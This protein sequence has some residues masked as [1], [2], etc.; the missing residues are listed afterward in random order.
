[1]T[2]HHLIHYRA[3]PFVKQSREPIHM[4]TVAVC[5]CGWESEEF[6]EMPQA[7]RAWRKHNDEEIKAEE[8]LLQEQLALV[9]ARATSA[10]ADPLAPNV[11][12]YNG[13][14]YVYAVDLLEAL[15]KP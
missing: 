6:V 7:Q 13:E 1:M 12:I 2:E 9:G 5:K 4:N 11:V 3:V 15:V 10:K 14:R 8:D